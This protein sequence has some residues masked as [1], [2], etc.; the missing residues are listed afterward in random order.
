MKIRMLLDNNADHS[1]RSSEI[2]KA[3][4]FLQQKKVAIFIISYNAQR[5]IPEVLSRIPSELHY[6]LAEIYLIDDSSQDNTVQTAINSGINLNLHNFNVYHTPYNRG[7]GGNQKL[8]YLYAMK[9]NFDYVILLN[10]DGQYAPE[11]IVEIINKFS[12]SEETDAVFASRMLMKWQ[13]L[14]SHMPFYKWIGNQLLTSFENSMLG[15]HLSEFH[16]GY[17]GYKVS[18]FSKIPFLYNSDDFHF[19]TEIII[20][21]IATKSQIVEVAMPS[22]YD[23]EICHVNGLKHIWNCI[24]SVIKFRLV[25]LGLFYEPNFDFGLFE[26]PNYRLKKTDDTLHQF[27]LKLEWKKDWSLIDLGA[28][29]GELSALLAEKVNQT[30]CVDLKKPTLSGNAIPM[31]MHLDDDFS[32]ALG[33]KTFDCVLAL[34]VIEHLSQPEVSAKRIFKILKPHGRFYASTGNI[35]FFLT[36][37]SLLLGQFNFGKRG[38][39]DLTHKRLFTIYSFKKLLIHAGF[40]ISKIHYFGPPIIDMIGDTFMLRILNRICSFLARLWPPMFAYQFLIEAERMEEVEEIFTKTLAS[41][42]TSCSKANDTT[43]NQGSL[44]EM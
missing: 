1:Q 40:R 11:M 10:G 39:L 36:R 4:A 26:A 20:Q 9:K 8:G 34:D 2:N 31:A 35:A 43:K 32:V 38:I 18:I 33:H 15:T 37:F 25:Q 42:S 14:K 28:N 17:R 21:L 23:N 30:I 6:H 29:E 5:F 7:Y 12:Q 16:T 41:K 19:D 13:A 27:I 44:I 22:H 24:R 3:V